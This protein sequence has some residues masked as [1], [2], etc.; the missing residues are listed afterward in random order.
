PPGTGVMV[1]ATD[2]VEVFDNTIRDNQTYNLAVLSYQV[3]GRPF[4]TKNGYDPVA[5]GVYVHNNRFSGGGDKPSGERGSFLEAL[6]GKPVPDIVYDGIR[7]PG[8]KGLAV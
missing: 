6:L 5:E 2:D 7:K 4:E 1:M 8:S 3:T